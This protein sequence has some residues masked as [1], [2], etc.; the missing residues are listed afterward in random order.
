MSDNI[1]S[2][3]TSRAT[4]RATILA[5]WMDGGRIDIYDGT[6]PLTSDTSITTQNLLTSF[7]IPDPSGI[8]TSGVLTLG[9]IAAAMIDTGGNATW[10]R[11][12]DDSDAVIFDCDV[13]ATGGGAMIEINNTSLVQ[14]GYVSVVSCVISE[15]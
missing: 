4:S 9:V 12:F 14:G 11:A 13:G 5:G 2:F 6:R 10:A 3:T 15:M 8:V 1:L 7:T